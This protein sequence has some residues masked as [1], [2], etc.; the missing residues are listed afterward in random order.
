M[1]KLLLRKLTTLT[2]LSF[3][4]IRF[5][6][7][8][9]QNS[10]LRGLYSERACFIIGNGPSLN[11][12]DL[13]PLSHIHTFTVNYFFKHKDFLK[14][15]PDFYVVLEPLTDLSAIFYTNLFNKLKSLDD[16]KVFLRLELRD[17]MAKNDPLLINRCTGLL[18]GRGIKV[19]RRLASS[20]NGIFDPADGAV[21]ASL[22]IAAELGFKKVFLIGCDFNHIFER[23]E[24]HFY[25]DQEKTY[26]EGK[27]NLVL[28]RNLVAYLEKME[29]L[30]KALKKKGVEVFNAGIG[31]LTDT[32]PRIQ[33]EKAL[34]IAQSLVHP[35]R[36][37]L[38]SMESPV[39]VSNGED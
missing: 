16:T 3:T 17:Y 1:L 36:S 4:R 11:D 14:I 35:S 34:K 20:L 19:G 13:L 7:Q 22:M 10:H 6:E 28:A 27:S 12:M 15:N 39:S 29:V 30:N 33:Y 18:T 23:R 21:F 8:L 32:F 2:K 31:G 25:E 38:S 9:R 26:L 37:K 24:A 5:Q